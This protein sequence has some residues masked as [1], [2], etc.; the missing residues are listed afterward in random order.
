[1]CINKFPYHSDGS[2]QIFLGQPHVLDKITAEKNAFTSKAS[3]QEANLLLHQNQDASETETVRH[4]KI[5]IEQQMEP[6]QRDIKSPSVHVLT[7]HLKS[8]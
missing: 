5:P 7:F 1:M 8:G 3:P 4:V 2:L 6:A